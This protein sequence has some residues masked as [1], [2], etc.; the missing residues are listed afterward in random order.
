MLAIG[1]AG[2][3]SY[4]AMA[5]TAGSYFKRNFA[6]GIATGAF[7]N[8]G[9]AFLD[10]VT[11]LPVFIAKLGGSAI[12]IGLVSSLHGAGWF[13]PQIFASRLAETRP[14]VIGLFRS[15]SLFRIAS[16]FAVVYV[17][18]NVGHESGG[19][20]LPLFILLLYIA[21]VAG[22]F[23]AVPFLEVISK[24]IPTRSRGGF[25]GTRR[26][27]GGL[28]GI[29]AGAAVGLI[30]DERSERLW[31]S[32]Q[33]FDSLETVTRRMGLLGH[34]FPD[35]FGIVFLFG[36]VFMSAGIILFCFAGEPP[37]QTVERS[38]RMWTHVRS[39]FQLLVSNSNYRRF[40]MDRACW[41]LAAM[42]F[43]FYTTYAYNELGM[44]TNMVGLFLSI[45]V[46]SGVLSNS[47]WGVLLD[48]SGN[49]IVLVLTSALTAIPP[50]AVLVVDRLR[51]GS[52]IPD[53]LPVAVISFTFLVNGLVRSGRIIAGTTYLLE[54]APEGK[55]P[56][57]VGFMNSFTSPFMLSPLLAGFILQLFGT[58]VL[59]AICLFFAL[60]SVVLTI[61]LHEPR[62]TA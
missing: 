46:G 12:L 54:F 56:L 49:R 5:T 23:A 4:G 2:R 40:F 7:V 51:T 62:N 25:F 45:W 22:G 14:R 48:R 53:W 61:G 26:L 59:F 37:A 3:V 24:T 33:W 34:A 32:G 10:P 31:M 19:P 35:N 15:I 21:H 20:F 30:L 47:V 28:A 38:S 57:Y 8:L 52:A 55:R 50:V 17:V 1:I 58:Q 29:V 27:I 43:P 9:L 13:V 11:V 44:S 60:V 39:G 6:L 42:A 18:M 41:Q 36:A 16:L